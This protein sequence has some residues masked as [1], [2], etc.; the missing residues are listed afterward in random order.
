MKVKTK[1]G[2]EIDLVPGVQ[3]G[4][5]MLRD[6]D[7]RGI[8]LIGSSLRGCFFNESLL[9]DSNL[10]NCD[11]SGAV[12]YRT[13]LSGADLSA[14]ILND[15]YWNEVRYSKTT[16]WPSGF[17]AP[18][19]RDPL[20]D[21]IIAEQSTYYESGLCVIKEL[22][23]RDLQAEIRPLRDF[24]TGYDVGPITS[25][26]DRKGLLLRLAQILTTGYWTY[27]SSEED[28]NDLFLAF[29]GDSNEDEEQF[30]RSVLFTHV[31]LML[32]FIGVQFYEVKEDGSVLVSFDIENNVGEFLEK[33]LLAIFEIAAR[34]AIA[35]G[36]VA[37][38]GDDNSEIYDFED[39]LSSLRKLVNKTRKNKQFKERI[40]QISGDQRAFQASYSIDFSEFNDPDEAGFVSLIDY[41]GPVS[42]TCEEKL[43]LGMVAY[44][45]YSSEGQTLSD[46]FEADNGGEF[47]SDDEGDDDLLDGDDDEF[48]DE[49]DEEEEEESI[50]TID[51]NFHRLAIRLMGIVSIEEG[52]SGQFKA[53]LRPQM[54]L[55]KVFKDLGYKIDADF[56]KEVEGFVVLTTLGLF[57]QALEF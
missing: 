26:E 30:I 1:K 19:R 39:D 14:A 40:Q 37:L 32:K 11:L 44:T 4:G 48:L 29:T 33:D 17:Q 38:H 13:D 45:N 49:D 36:E 9:N 57:E 21:V 22:S 41:S 16:I 51:C 47:E 52:A 42:Y 24:T 10:R 31:V 5:E 8:D 20:E 35:L 46:L 43:I 23:T 6:L 12:F 15:C 7:L 55:S 53:V 56:E 34:R 50:D 27:L 25:A 18:E 2:S 3:L 28:W 54:S